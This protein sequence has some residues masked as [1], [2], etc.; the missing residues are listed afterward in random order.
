MLHFRRRLR[1]LEWL[2]D[3]LFQSVA[4]AR[5]ILANV[6]DLALKLLPLGLHFGVVARINCYTFLFGTLVHI[7]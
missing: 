1:L 4:H 6:L 5:H 7:K 2:E 3:E